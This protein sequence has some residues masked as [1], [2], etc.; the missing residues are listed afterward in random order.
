MEGNRVSRV[1]LLIQGLV[2]CL[3]EIGRVEDPTS[4]RNTMQ[5]HRR[6]TQLGASE[7]MREVRRRRTFT[8]DKCLSIMKFLYEALAL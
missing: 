5:V 2:L 6:W 8:I 7:I 4:G 1:P 3:E